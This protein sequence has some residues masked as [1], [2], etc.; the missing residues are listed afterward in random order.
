MDHEQEQ[1]PIY[2]FHFQGAT[3]SSAS[4]SSSAAAPSN[5]N[6]TSYN[7]NYHPNSNGGSNGN[8]SNGHPSYNGHSLAYHHTP[9]Q[10]SSLQPELLSPTNQQHPDPFNAQHHLPPSQHSVGGGYHGSHG[11]LQKAIP[12]QVDIYQSPSQAP[13]HELINPLLGRH[14]SSH[15]G[16]SSDLSSPHH[17]S[18]HPYQQQQ[19]QHPPSPYYYQ[20]Q[21]KQYP[22]QHSDPATPASTTASTLNSGSTASTPSLS[23]PASALPYQNNDYTYM[24]G[25]QALPHVHKHASPAASFHIP[26][27]PTTPTNG[28]QLASP[29]SAHPLGAGLP[30]A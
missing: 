28:P 9:H 16:H 17:P 22:D 10:H 18:H 3:A 19:Q 2:P 27:T 29:T 4:S 7:G 26:T 25:Q 12:H 30:L 8:G 14:I 1:G 24:S 6:H 20:Q 13:D 15:P 11:D 5:G 21:Q 23:S